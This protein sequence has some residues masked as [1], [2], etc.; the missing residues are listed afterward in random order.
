[1][2]ANSYQAHI[3]LGTVVEPW[4]EIAALQWSG[5]ER[6]YFFIKGG[7]GVAYIPASV[8][9]AKHDATSRLS[10]EEGQ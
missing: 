1:M 4:G 5:G 9:E 10:K 2:N 6:Y 8:V 3:P 7:H